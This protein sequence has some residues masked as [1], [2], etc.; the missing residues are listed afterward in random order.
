[1]IWRAFRFFLFQLAGGFFGYWLLP[2]V[3]PEQD[4]VAGIACASLIWVLLDLRRG[5]KL[6]TWLRQA[7]TAQSPSI[8]GLWGEVADRTRR[9]LRQR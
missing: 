2:M 8:G 3:D 1:M 9:L 4:V 6:L 5:D 7:D